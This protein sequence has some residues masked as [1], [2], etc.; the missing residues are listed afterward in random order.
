V[1][2]GKTS[3]RVIIA[4]PSSVGTSPRTWTSRFRESLSSASA[5]IRSD[6]ALAKAKLQKTYHAVEGPIRSDFEGARCIYQASEQAILLAPDA[7]FEETGLQ[8]ESLLEG[9]IPSLISMVRIV[10]TSTFVGSAIG[11]IVGALCGGAGA[12]PGAVIGADVGFDFGML[13]FTWAGLKILVPFIAEGLGDLVFVIKLGIGMAWAARKLTG[14]AEERQV[15]DAAYQLAR[16]A[17]ILVRLIIQ[18]CMAYILARIGA[19][20]VRGIAKTA[21]RV[22][23]GDAAEAIAE[24][25]V[26]DLV[27][28]LRASRL[29]RGFADWFEKNW[30][31][32]RD[33][34][35][36]KPT[37][38]GVAADGGAGTGAGKGPDA[39]PIEPAANGEESESGGG[40][41]RK[42]GSHKTSQK[43]TSQMAQ[44]GWTDAQI[45]E[46]VANGEQYPAP[47]NIN[48][49]NGATRYVNPTTGR[50][51]VIDN[52][53]NEVLHVGGDGFRY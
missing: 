13:I 48:P 18:G 17:G 16:S 19:G 42:W 3:A 49:A 32:L 31:D 52:T 34:P 37:Q 11:G 27:T 47:N 30:R 22:A 21:G 43:V 51:V 1:N 33:N 28:V 26:K 20:A 6:Y 38:A 14:K 5:D 25:A 10:G 40:G 2:D 41:K 24:S 4:P 15:R 46:A 29:S 9:F 23:G 39:P 44:R 45:E 35:K 8:I 36:L 50:S 12:V 7:I 53:T